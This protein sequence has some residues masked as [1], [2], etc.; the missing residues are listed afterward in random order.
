MSGETSGLASADQSATSSFDDKKVGST[1]E[2]PKHEAKSE[3]T[4]THWIELELV[5]EDDAPIVG[6]P[7]RVTLG[8]ASVIE[9]RTGKTGIVRIE[10]ID[11]GQC[12]VSFP[13]L[14]QAAWDS[15]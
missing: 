8:D 3:S 5:G 1:E 15:A 7:Y 2:C 4:S 9:G 13:A 14:D 10:G 6:E 12:Q 11:P